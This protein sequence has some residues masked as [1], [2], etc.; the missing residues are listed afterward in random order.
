MAGNYPDGD[1]FNENYVESAV[2]YQ[3]MDPGAPDGRGFGGTND[4]TFATGGRRISPDGVMTRYAEMESEA[5]ENSAVDG[6]SA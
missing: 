3:D 6:G 1:T 4:Y 5:A 2:P